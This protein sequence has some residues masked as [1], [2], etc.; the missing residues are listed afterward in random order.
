MIAVTLVVAAEA[1]ALLL[2]A[3]WY[4]YQLAVGS[5]V[6]S[7]WGAV[8]T[9]GLLL[10]FSAWLYAV[11]VYLYRGYRWTRAAALVAQLFV[12]TIGFPA[13]SSGLVLAGLAMLLPAATAI[14]LLFHNRV[15][16]YASRT[17]GSTPA[18]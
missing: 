3:C 4:G 6:L 18:L 8:F 13:L 14:V 12:L 16:S 1:T 2:A 5:P 15:I 17:G 7:F 9:L 11:A 10:A